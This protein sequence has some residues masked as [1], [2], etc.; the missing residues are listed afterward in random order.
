MAS[1][2]ALPATPQAGPIRPQPLSRDLFIFR[3]PEP[4]GG[5]ARLLGGMGEEAENIAV[6]AAL[7][8]A[9]GANETETEGRRSQ[10]A[11]AAKTS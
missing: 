3:Q 5:S 11:P 2:T 10:I 9:P 8:R 4:I 7:F 6:F 1:S